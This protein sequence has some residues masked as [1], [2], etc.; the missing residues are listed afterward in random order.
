MDAFFIERSVPEAALSG[1]P[2][3]SGAQWLIGKMAETRTVA[4]WVGLWYVIA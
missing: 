3:I 4:P 1:K 2:Q